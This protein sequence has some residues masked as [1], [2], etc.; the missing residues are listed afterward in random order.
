LDYLF[1]GR[2]VPVVASRLVDVEVSDHFPVWAE[3]ALPGRP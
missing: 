1:S 3:F 2:D